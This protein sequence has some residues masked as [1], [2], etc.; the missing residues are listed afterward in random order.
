MLRDVILHL[1]ISFLHVGMLYAVGP[2]RRRLTCRSC[3][4]YRSLHSG[5]LGTVPRRTR[6]P[7]GA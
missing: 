5:K 7:A 3:G 6:L 4:R 1:P 2:V